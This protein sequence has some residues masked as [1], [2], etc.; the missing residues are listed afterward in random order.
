MSQDKVSVIIR[1]FNRPRMLR[2]ALESVAAQTLPA[3]EVMLINDGGAS[4]QQLAIELGV[5][6][7]RW[8]GAEP[9]GAGLAEVDESDLGLRRP[10]SQTRP[11]IAQHPIVGHSH[12]GANQQRRSPPDSRSAQQSDHKSDEWGN[13]QTFEH[14]ESAMT[15]SQDRT[16]V[17]MLVSISTSSPGP[18]L[19]RRLL[20]ALHPAIGAHLIN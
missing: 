15:M 4:V 1:T 9:N 20:A 8:F 13:R 3:V 7:G 10:H 19:D 17:L 18:Q 6:R 5:Q 12:H 2:R 16:R 14:Q 11:P